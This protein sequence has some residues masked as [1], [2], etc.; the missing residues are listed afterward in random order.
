[1][2]VGE[3]AMPGMGCLQTDTVQERANDGIAVFVLEGVWAYWLNDKMKYF[4]FV[5][6]MV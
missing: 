2:R 4:V 6:T 5:L 1:L 3:S